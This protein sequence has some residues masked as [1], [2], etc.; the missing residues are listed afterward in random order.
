MFGCIWGDLWRCFSFSKKWYLF[1]RKK[2]ARFDKIVVITLS[3]FR[4]KWNHWNTIWNQSHCWLHWG[5]FLQAICKRFFELLL[6][7]LHQLKKWKIHQIKYMVNCDQIQTL[8]VVNFVIGG[9]KYP[10]S[11]EAYVYRSYRDGKWCL[12]AFH[13]SEQGKNFR[14]LV[15]CVQN[16][17]I[18][19]NIYFFIV[20]FC[21]L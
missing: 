1:G 12:T 13:S 4:I 18:K 6:L 7:H 11:A 21:N 14:F 5:I 2:L 17:Q 10:L 9:I 20:Q 3:C 16:F 15:T 19:I 8:P